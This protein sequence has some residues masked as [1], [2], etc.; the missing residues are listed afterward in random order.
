MRGV[1]ESG[2]R[3]G[4]D[5]GFGLEGGGLVAFLGDAGDDRDTAVGRGDE[6][7]DDVELLLV[8]EERA[9]A[10]VAEH[11]EALHAVDGAEPGAEA[12]D[13]VVVD[14]PSSVNGVTG[15]GFRPRRSRVIIVV[16]SLA[17]S[18]PDIKK[19]VGTFA[20]TIAIG[21][22]CGHCQPERGSGGPARRL[23]N[24][25]C[26]TRRTRWSGAGG[27]RV[28]LRDVAGEPASASRR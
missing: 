28:T 17:S 22:E 20:G 15:A 23:N 16:L 25:S 14:A 24:A 18:C 2:G 8:G 13:R 3:T 27:E 21:N 19:I 1:H 7:A 4:L 9:L 12:L 5:R 6:C 10:G 26:G 11:D